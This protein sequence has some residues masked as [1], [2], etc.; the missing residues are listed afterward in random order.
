MTC[1]AKP[2]WSTDVGQVLELAA[3][4]LRAADRAAQRHLVDDRPQPQA[5]RGEPA[6]PFFAEEDQALGLLQGEL[7]ELRGSRRR[8]PRSAAGRE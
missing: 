1:R 8:T 2:G 6:L 4:E 7:A 3:H 5:A